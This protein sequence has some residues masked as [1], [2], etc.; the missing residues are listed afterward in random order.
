MG[1]QLD[2]VLNV[3]IKLRMNRL[4]V[5]L[6]SPSAMSPTQALHEILN[7]CTEIILTFFFF[8][9]HLNLTPTSLQT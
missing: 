8:S 3:D 7:W 1:E 9:Q 5:L 2:K 6:A 4:N